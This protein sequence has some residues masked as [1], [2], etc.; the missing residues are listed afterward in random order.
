M[1]LVDLITADNFRAI[2]D[3]FKF[4]YFPSYPTHKTTALFYQITFN[5][6]TRN[7]PDLSPSLPERF[8]GVLYYSLGVDSPTVWLNYLGR[9]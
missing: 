3:F 4:D 7:Y 6:L 2:N 8:C 1:I 9:Q 5:R